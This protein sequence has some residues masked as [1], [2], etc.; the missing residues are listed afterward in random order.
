MSIKKGI[1]PNQSSG[2]S[3]SDKGYFADQAALEAAYPVGEAG[4][5]AL[6]GTTDTFWSWDTDTNAWKDSGISD[7]L[8]ASSNLSDVSSVPSSRGNLGVNYLGDW[9][10]ST[11]T[12]TLPN[13]P[14]SA[15]Y[16]VGDYYTVVNA[17]TQFS[18]TYVINDRNIVVDAGGGNLAWSRVSYALG[19]GY[20]VDEEALS[21]AFPGGSKNGNLATLQTNESIYLWLDS[22]GGW[23]PAVNEITIKNLF[24]IIAAKSSLVVGD[25]LM[26]SDSED[27]GNLKKVD[28][29]DLAFLRYKEAY[30]ASTNT[31]ALYPAPTGED[32]RAGVFY[33]VSVAGD[34]FTTQP[35]AVGDILI[36][37]TSTPSTINDWVILTT[38]GG[39]RRFTGI[40]AGD[41]GTEGT[42]IT[43][44]GSTYDSDLKVSDINGGNA[45]Q[46]IMHRHST[47][48]PSTLVGARSNSNTTAHADITNGMVNM[49]IAGAG[50]AGN[51]YKIFNALQFS[52]DDTGTISQTSAPGKID[53][54]TTP[55][56]SV[57]PAVA[58][59][60][61][62]DKSVEL[63]N[64][65]ANTIAILNANKQ[66]ASSSYTDTTALL[67]AMV[68]D[69]GSGGT[70]GLVPAPSAGDA[71][72][73]KFL[74]ADGTWEA[75]SGEWT[76][77]A[78]FA[79][80]VTAVGANDLKIRLTADLTATAN[81]TWTDG[82]IPEIDFN[83][84]FIDWGGSP[85][86][87]SP[88]NINFNSPTLPT[89]FV[90][91]S[92]N[93]FGGHKLAGGDIFS[94]YNSNIIIRGI[95]YIKY[96]DN[97]YGQAYTEGQL[98]YSQSV[99]YT[100]KADNSSQ[101]FTGSGI[102]DRFGTVI[103]E[104]G[105]SSCNLGFYLNG[106]RVDHLILTGE[107]SPTGNLFYSAAGALYGSIGCLTYS[108][109]NDSFVTVNGSI[110]QVIKTSTGNPK[111]VYVN[112]SPLFDS[113]PNHNG[114]VLSAVS[115]N[116]YPIADQ[117]AVATLYLTPAGKGNY[118]S[119]KNIQSGNGAW[120]S[121]PSP[122][123]PISLTGLTANTL[124]DVFIYD[125][126][127]SIAAET[128]AWSSS[129]FGSSARA[130]ALAYEDGA[131]VKSSD[132]T[133][134]YKG[135]FRT[136]STTGQTEDS[137][138]KRL[139][140]SYHNRSVRDFLLLANVSFYTT[141]TTSFVPWNN[142]STNQIQFVVGIDGESNLD[143]QL[144]WDMKG[145]SS[146]AVGMYGFGINS[147]SALT[148][149]NG[150]Q[151]YYQN[152][153]E[154]GSLSHNL[155]PTAGAHYICPLN[156]TNGVSVSFYYNSPGVGDW[157]WP[158][159]ANLT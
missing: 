36:P 109:S 110:G 10:A 158:L 132:P 106:G 77:V 24:D 19:A 156:K 141:S 89:G 38:V 144:A 72:A 48:I 123:I 64:L 155:R 54:L 96:T 136:T 85:T 134:K 102:N 113:N 137:L 35:V 25:L 5:Y 30:N 73:G 125:N 97:G 34:F 26:L 58:M 65:T 79:E 39:D 157:H 52:A 119:V 33:E 146:S 3:S 115:G 9:D 62:N 17:G 152:I 107:C 131:L 21:A 63:P 81:I 27:S 120:V 41:P 138:T 159:T 46:F 43:V 94:G 100:P 61:R 2:T 140:W 53:F 68:G 151:V 128:L 135:T 29:G 129:T 78:T 143:M 67:D 149:I 23:Y 49:Q 40:I 121:Y 60:I 127:G 13:P 83:G 16:N 11:N 1:I 142:D 84:Y 32:F 112:Q 80:F 37:K 42:G 87:T 14:T 90:Q 7:Y 92:I 15:D 103:V 98:D 88:Y 59:T 126:G 74:K 47:F 105:G 44:N 50:Y 122:E 18:N 22:K 148:R 153:E 70:K 31:P 118:E 114:L 124:Y 4:W 71:A 150:G 55:D 95:G 56:S 130:T 93:K 154:T 108:L 8:K 101:G 116:P 104:G 51:D 82:Y 139:V 99:L 111:I 117:T 6:V 20:F 12:P 76:E 147:T 75:T 28:Y 66:I 69:S 91:I 45:A 57:T 133:R 86:P 145:S